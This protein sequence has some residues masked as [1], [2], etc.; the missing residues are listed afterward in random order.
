MGEGP[1]DGDR[2]SRNLLYAYHINSVLYAGERSLD[3]K[4]K[5]RD[6]SELLEVAFPCR[7]SLLQ[8]ALEVFVIAAGKCFVHW[9]GTC[10]IAP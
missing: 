2:R 5:T 10:P 9:K 4:R 6:E 8:V 1:R 7:V 3:R